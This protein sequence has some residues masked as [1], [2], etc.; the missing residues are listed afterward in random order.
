MMREGLT[1]A[2]A[3]AA[4]IA[5]AALIAFA[6]GAPF[7]PRES[8]ESLIEFSLRL[9]VGVS[10]T[11]GLLALPAIALSEARRVRGPVYWIGVGLACAGIA[12]LASPAG[13]LGTAATLAAMGIAGGY[14][15]WRLAGRRAGRLAAAVFASPPD[16]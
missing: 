13:G 3:L 16:E 1:L 9:A 15:Y 4:A 10:L 14:V 12:G 11:G 7:A 8:G 6:S 2:G 5:A